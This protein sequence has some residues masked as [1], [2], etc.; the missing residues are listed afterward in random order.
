MNS[1]K[2]LIIFLIAGIGISMISGCTPSRE[3][4]ASPNIIYILAD[5]LGYAELGCYGQE[6]IE[7]PNLDKLASSGMRFTQHYAGAPV[8][9][10]S[11]CV[12]L[13]GLHTGHAQ[14]R[15][16]DEWRSRGDVWNFE[17]MAKDPNLEGQRPR[18]LISFMA[19]IASGRHIPFFRFTSGGIQRKLS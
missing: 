19:I 13:T 15:G 5:D 18:V 9:A 12:L 1:I 7:T 3:A 14:I 10:P 17:A 8:C 11:R 4:E 2:P 16:N 6:K